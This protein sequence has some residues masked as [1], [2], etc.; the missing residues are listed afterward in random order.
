M[1][2]FFR[3]KKCAPHHTTLWMWTWIEKTPTKRIN[4]VK[5]NQNGKKK[6]KKN[7]LL[8]GTLDFAKATKKLHKRKNFCFSF[9]QRANPFFSSKKMDA[10]F[11]FPKMI[12]FPIK[13]RKRVIDSFS[14]LFF[15]PF[16]SKKKGEKKMGRKNSQQVNFI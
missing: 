14:T 1:R 12:F 13:K 7:L 3:K 5:K 8:E 11:F 9:S 10:G 15:H 16:F 6:Q 4:K 2:F